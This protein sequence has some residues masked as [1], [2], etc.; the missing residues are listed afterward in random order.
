MTL[1][2]SLIQAIFFLIPSK[3][4]IHSEVLHRSLM[5]VLILFFG[6]ITLQEIQLYIQMMS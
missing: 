5:S 3:T 4:E 6:Q 2:T 1:A